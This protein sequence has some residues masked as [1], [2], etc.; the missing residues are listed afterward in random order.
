MLKLR[1]Q[2]E[3]ISLKERIAANYKK[4]RRLINLL[5]QSRGWDE[6]AADW[7]LSRSMVHGL[8]DM[9]VCELCYKK[10]DFAFLRLL[11][12]KDAIERMIQSGKQRPTI[13]LNTPK[14][15]VDIRFSSQKPVQITAITRGKMIVFS[16][17]SANQVETRQIKHDTNSPIFIFGDVVSLYCDGQRLTDC[18]FLRCQQI[19]SISLAHNRIKE[20]EFHDSTCNLKKI[21]LRGNSISPKSILQLLKQMEPFVKKDLFDE[22]PTFF[23]SVDS[24]EEIYSMA[25]QK[26]CVVINANQF[27]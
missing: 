15:T 14:A 7:K 23:I 9:A 17:E 26:R 27:R 20:L 13:I 25:K 21:D 4:S 22:A 6:L 2:L 18:C 10:S 24:P 1:E 5:G 11:A 3:L 8:K 16:Y 19:E 12:Y